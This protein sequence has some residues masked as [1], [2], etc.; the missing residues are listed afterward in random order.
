MTKHAMN[1]T[2][3]GAGGGKQ[4]PEANRAGGHPEAGAATHVTI[5]VTGM[6][7]AA[8]QGR[9]QR[10]LTKTPGVHAANVNL[11][12]HNATVDFDPT[13]TSPEQLVA[14]IRSTGYDAKVPAPPPASGQ[15]SAAFAEQGEQERARSEELREL[16]WKAGVSLALGL[17][18]MLLSMPIM[19]AYTHLV[20]T[21]A[22]DPFLHWV[23]IKVN[24]PLASALPFLFT[25]NPSL[26]AYLLL[27]LTTFVMVWAGRHIYR[28]AWTA[29]R[30]HSADMNTLIAVGTG[31]AYLYSVVATVVPGLFLSRGLAPDLYYEA[32]VLIIALVLLG[33]TLEARAKRQT[34]NALRRLVDLQPKSARVRRDGRE[35]DLP[36]EE[37]RRGDE[38]V[39]RPGERVP[40]DGEILDGTS[41]VD[42]SMIT[43]ESIPVL[44]RLGDRVVGG[45]INRT[46][47]FRAR[48]TTL[49][50]ESALARIVTLMR[51]AQGT[52][53]P[54]QHLA[55]RVSAIF[56]PTVLSIA[57]A[58]FVIWFVASGT[59]PSGAAVRALASSIAVLIIAC[60][61]A[62]G[63]AVPTA[64]MV[65]TG[66]GAELG[67]LIKG[68]E[69]LERSRAID[70]VILDKTGTLTEGRP[71]VTD[72]ALVPNAPNAPDAGGER[73][74][75][76]LVASVERLSEHPL[77]EAIVNHARSLGVQLESVTQFEA[78]VGRGV[79]GVVGDVAVIAGN[80]AMMREHGVGITPLEARADALASEAKTVVYTAVSRGSAKTEDRN[81]HEAHD[82]S[83]AEA[84]TLLGVLAIADP[85]RA[86]SKPAVRALTRMGL[87]VV[88]LTG[89][90]RP[91]AE[92]IAREA[93]IDEVVAE[94]LPDGKVAEV[95]RL[96]DEGHVVAM[97]GDGIND[98]P[99][100][101]RADVGV[102]IGTG[103]DVAIEAS[104][105][106]LMRPDLKGVV[107]AIALARRTMRTMKQ[108]LFWA[109]VY[110][111]VGIPIAAGA[112]YPHFG[113]L[114]SPV[115]AS[116][117]MALSSVSV[118][119]N[120]LRLRRF[121]GVEV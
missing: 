10:A 74:L 94:V 75:L 68:G 12:M 39:V 100:L 112:L 64:V 102:A 36:V 118:V 26:L 121:R 108:N 60:P 29:F 79:E 99:A 116:A 90:N 72:V 107:D 61:C 98:A 63:L 62:M 48:A 111:V 35:I 19:T 33:N 84:F 43:G 78:L 1:H 30:H 114:L 92:A 91:T 56:V 27:A 57:I 40:V 8:C 104:D 17:V 7:C 31:A 82:E 5:P 25:A 13:V 109:F 50:E 51:E 42:E 24:A 54:I 55:D 59:P 119:S 106:T 38:V 23:M 76:R 85:I 120:S 34:S 93:G 53:A 9:V 46:G 80:E 20:P 115:L 2:T 66:K 89:D 14:T 95:R 105:V 21:S 18:A 69:A 58:T 117:A 113:L 97:V 71:A 47:A 103:T 67:V 28:R 3:V 6:T 16:G 41:A 52:R 81:K 87:D 101:A 65:A 37:V 86:T 110:N 88:L 4:P 22:A 70:T 49:G 44:K 96:Q 73:E 32:V 11:M 77:A 45:T 83:E 15:W